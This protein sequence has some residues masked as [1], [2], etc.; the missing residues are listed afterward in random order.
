MERKTPRSLNQRNAQLLEDLANKTSGIP[1]TSEKANALHCGEMVNKVKL[2]GR[3]RLCKLS[4]RDESSD[5]YGENTVSEDATS[6]AIDEP[7]DIRSIL[8][9]LSSKLDSLSI[10]KSSMYLKKQYK[11]DSLGL[12]NIYDSPESGSLQS[13]NDRSVKGA[14]VEPSSTNHT[15][16]KLPATKTG[17]RVDLDGGFSFSLVSDDDRPTQGRGHNDED[18]DGDSFC[19][20]TSSPLLDQVGSSSSGDASKSSA[21]ES[22]LVNL[23]DDDE[24]EEYNRCRSAE[25]QFEDP[26]EDAEPVMFSN[27]SETCKL[28]GNIAK[29]LYPHQHDGLK[30]LWS[31]HC[32]K[33]GGILG[34]DMGLGKTMQVA[35]FLSGLF[36]SS[37][38][39]RVLIVSPKTLLQHWI[40]ELSTVGLSGR[41][42]EYFGSSTS[43]RQYELK[44]ILQVG[45][46]L[47]TTYDIVRNNSKSLKGDYYQ[48]DNHD[49]EDESTWD[50]V[51]LDEGHIIKNPSTQRA[52]S[53]LEIPC[54]HRII[55]SGTPI[56]NNLKELWALF[57]FC[58]PEILG[59]KKEF[60]ERYEYAILRGNEKNASDREKQIGST[61]ARDLRERIKPYFLRRLKS[62]VF[63][64]N[65]NTNTS[66]L[67]KK[68][69]LIIWLRLSQNQR[70]LYEAFLESEMVTSS[71]DD[72][73]KKKSSFGASALSALT[74]L[75]KICDHPS[76][77]TKRATD[78]ILEGMEKLLN[79]DDLHRVDEMASHLAKMMSSQ[80]G[81]KLQ[82]NVSCKIS[83]LIALLEN[84]IA[85][86]HSVL[87]FSQTRKMLDIV[88][89][90]IGSK[91]YSFL[92]IDGTTKPS[93]RERLVQEFQ[94]GL[95]APIFLLT[96]QVG[97]LGLTLTR[98]D[99]VIVVDPA[100]NPSMDN[101]SVDRA[102]R[103]GQFKDVLVY[104]LMTCG[105][106]E[107]KI[108]KMQVFKGGL[109]KIATEH[110]EQTRYFSQRDLRELFS[111]PPQGFDV[112]LTQL[113]LE[114]EHGSDHV[115]EASLSDHIKFL[116]SLGIAA[117][118]HH[119]LLFSKAAT[120]LAL[121]QEAD[122]LPCRGTMYLGHSSARSFSDYVPAG[123]EDALNPKHWKYPDANSPIVGS[124]AVHAER[125]K[126]AI[127][128]LYQTLDNEAIISKLPDKGENLHRKIK[129]LESE[130]DTIEKSDMNHDHKKGK[131]N[132]SNTPDVVNIDD[133]SDVLQKLSVERKR[134]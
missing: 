79:K 115:M 8:N 64:D 22:I 133:I 52:K 101:Q 106:I 116:E 122:I 25:S 11:N 89:E 44:Y 7:S 85:E 124:K 102:Y 75:K 87:I 90:A 4:S 107:E 132:P 129:V 99:R 127:K 46:I 54:A 134:E 105:T 59:D 53:L 19:S 56:Q 119:S 27:G 50:Y 33:T 118:S 78:D 3:R 36:A 51:I 29:M 47:L 12:I 16:R 14:A 100:W 30:W 108:Y 86:D 6:S 112:S 74:V 125:L 41:I 70:Q 126:E 1:P 35:A 55:I 109:S 98:A 69:E 13:E 82:S 2:K 48:I 77:L 121:R 63:V 40:R 95:G 68:H 60:K 58:C 31:L 24:D 104:R 114:E 94:E 71:F 84:M 61:V 20:T 65:G 67:S 17:K 38:I 5:S 120:S 113:Q 28:S 93:E 34:D 26:V 130:L 76:L 73:K 9:D 92:R 15:D 117:V 43:S 42:R 23:S 123:K 128:R 49:E 91:G 37:L 80:S 81:D 97:G 83:F 57:N 32:K 10:E 18:D 39:K 96:S 88:Q 110:K 45:G 21:S 62:E 66:K 111:L 131:A 103:I 72:K